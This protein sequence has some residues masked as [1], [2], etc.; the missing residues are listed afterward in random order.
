MDSDSHCYSE[1]PSRCSGQLPV[2]DVISS[3][4]AF[5]FRRSRRNNY[6]LQ[7]ALVILSFHVTHIVFGRELSSFHHLR[8]DSGMDLI[9]APLLSFVELD[10]TPAMFP[11]PLAHSQN[12]SLLGFRNPAP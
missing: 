9:S 8:K 5:T 6:Y 1:A 3:G 11:T 10:V 7:L 2:G 12:S 4:F